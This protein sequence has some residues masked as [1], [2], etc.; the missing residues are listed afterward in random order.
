MAIAQ[1]ADPEGVRE[2][3]NGRNQ[4][5]TRNSIVSEMAILRQQPAGASFPFVDNPP[6]TSFALLRTV[7]CRSARNEGAEH[8]PIEL[9]SHP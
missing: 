2:H 9:H 7:L 4:A 3:I 6:S 5:Y 1:Q 8:G